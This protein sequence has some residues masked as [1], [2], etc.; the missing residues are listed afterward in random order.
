MQNDTFE[1]FD[2]ISTKTKDFSDKLKKLEDTF[3]GIQKKRVDLEKKEK[4]IMDGKTVLN[5]EV[6][7]FESD[8]LTLMKS[9]ITFENESISS[10]KELY[11]KAIAEIEY[12]KKAESTQ[13]GVVEAAQKVLAE[14]AQRAK[15]EAEYR[16]KVEEAQRKL[17]EEAQKA[18]ASAAQQIQNELTK[19]I[20]PEAAAKK[21]E[22]KEKVDEKVFEIPVKANKE[23][24]KDKK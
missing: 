9:M 19:G 5:T 24:I 1:L 12:R 17:I 21:E 4:E 15:A 20:A 18:Q 16:A 14:A 22:G 2:N 13:R 8:L 3:E 11:R 23:P 6:N 7:R 10:S